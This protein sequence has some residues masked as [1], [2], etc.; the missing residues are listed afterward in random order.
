MNYNGR[1]FDPIE[2][3]MR[4]RRDPFQDVHFQHVIDD[5]A[6]LESWMKNKKI[7]NN[8]TLIEKLAFLRNVEATIRTGTAVR[9]TQLAWFT[10]AIGTV[11][12][13]FGFLIGIAA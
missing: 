10:L 1:T 12:A 9:R 11:A 13:G 4:E 7:Q 6:A 3:M 2:S 5:I 8:W